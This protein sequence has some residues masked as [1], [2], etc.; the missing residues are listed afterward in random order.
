MFPAVAHHGMDTTAIRRPAPST[1][2]TVP[3]GV[4][5]R[6]RT[7]GSATA[8]ASLMASLPPQKALRADSEGRQKHQMS[9]E[10]SESRV[11]AKSDRLA[12]AQHHG[13]DEGPPDGTH[14]ADDDSLEGV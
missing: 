11:D 1:M 5:R 10:D 9:G 3:D 6:T 2:A 13:A 8:T 4:W 12:Y 14:A 7:G